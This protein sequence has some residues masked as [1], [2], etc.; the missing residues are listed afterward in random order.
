MKYQQ[1]SVPVI[2]ARSDGKSIT[3]I[4]ETFEGRNKGD[5]T[6]LPRFFCVA[7]RQRPSR[8][9]CVIADGDVHGAGGRLR[10][11]CGSARLGRWLAINIHFAVCLCCTA[12]TANS[13]H[14]WIYPTQFPFPQA[15]IAVGPLQSYMRTL[16]RLDWLMDW[17]MCGYIQQRSY[18]QRLNCW[19]SSAGCF[20]I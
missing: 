14:G 10:N 13:A 3:F 1:Q 16:K 6:P 7:P 19:T 4:S 18:S 5:G 15:Q 2:N 9:I 12:A 11:G 20:K 8:M 17:G